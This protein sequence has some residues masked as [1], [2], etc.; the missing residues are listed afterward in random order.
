MSAP[1][2]LEQF[3]GFTPGPL[4][5][6]RHYSERILEIQDGYGRPVAR[7][8]YSDSRPWAEPDAQLIVA[9]PGLLAL[10]RS[11]SE[12]CERQRAEIARLRGALSPLLE[13]ANES[14]AP[15][16]QGTR[17]RVALL[18]CIHAARAALRQT[19]EGA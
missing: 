16:E 8:P 5:V 18:A 7:V 11:Y 15:G 9:A 12:Q 1:L 3:A 17:G 10:A 6:V 19:G 4:T 14:H 2:D 13:A